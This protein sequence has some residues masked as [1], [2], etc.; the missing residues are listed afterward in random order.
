Q[1]LRDHF[2]DV[3]ESLIRAGARDID[4]RRKL[5]GAPDPSDDVLQYVAVR[6]PLLEWGLRK[7]V[8]A[9]RGIE[10][11]SAAVVTGLVLE[12][13]GVAG[14]QVDGRIL[15]TPIVVDAM[16]RRS[17]VRGW[18]Q[19]EGLDVPT[20]ERSEC[21]VIYYSRY[22]RVRAGCEL[23]D[24]PWILGPRGDLG[25]MGFST[26][27]GDNGTFAAVLAIPIGLPEF[28]GLAREGRCETAIARIPLVARWVNPD[29]SDPITAVQPM[30]GLQ[31]S[32]LRI[33]D[34][35][36]A[37]WFPVSDAL[38]HTDPVLA[39]GLSFALIHARALRDALGRHSALAD[40][41]A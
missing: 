8:L 9:E 22:Y 15:E 12:R 7:A 30:G 3:Y 38:C 26:F 36:P 39:H 2:A 1:E 5:P 33:G 31:S 20:Q 23:P 11:M 18:L 19:S 17:P 27:P 21:G 10:V 37:G 16:G 25:Y 28:K 29:L 24:G 13:G 4:A 6:R 40:A 41:S 35:H 14:V 34:G 32:I